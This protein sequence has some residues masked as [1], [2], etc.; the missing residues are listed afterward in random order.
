MFQRNFSILGGEP[1]ALQNLEMTEEVV[2]AVRQAYPN[3]KIF[4]WT[5]YTMEDL[6]A[7]PLEKINQILNQINVLIDGPYIEKCRDLNLRL[8]G[9]TNQHI[10]E[11]VN[12]EWIRIE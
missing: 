3:I 12:N 5:G 1:L 7:R 8:R 2:Q 4:L 11:K 9:S 10:Y 6:Q